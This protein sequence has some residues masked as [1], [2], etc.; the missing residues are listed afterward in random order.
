MRRTAIA[1]A[2]LACLVL[3]AAGSSAGTQHVKLFFLQGE[4]FS[5]VARAVPAAT[6]AAALHALLAGPTVKERNAGYRTAIPA[7][8]RIARLSATANRA[9]VSIVEPK[10]KGDFALSLLPA[11][12]AQVTFTVRK[13]G[14]SAVTLF[15][16]GHSI[17]TPSSTAPPEPPPP[18]PDLF[19]DT[20]AP[21]DTLLVQTQL[22]ALHYLPRDA[23]TGKWDYRSEEAVM[24]FQAWNGLGRDGDAGPITLGALAGSPVPTPTVLSQGRHIEVYRDRGVL[25]LVQDGQVLRAIH[26]STGRSPGFETPSGTFTVFR[27]ERFSWSAPYKVWLPYA[28]Y[29]HNGI[30]FHAYPEVPATPASHGCVRV[31]YP[32][33]AT[34]YAFAAYG[35]TVDVY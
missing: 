6:P 11:Q 24:A 3:P 20:P 29:F 32:E 22:N 16:N 14:L 23:V 2:L 12:A 28:S 17:A 30:A 27:K 5:A 31:S 13:L 8:A 25:L 10:P 35:L 21:A 19:P 26:V 9:T 4:Q 18:P 1:A 33:A 34:V 15:I 7:G